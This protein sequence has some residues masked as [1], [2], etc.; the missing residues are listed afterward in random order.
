[1][2]TLI[3]ILITLTLMGLAL[4]ARA[5]INHKPL[6]PKMEVVDKATWNPGVEKTIIDHI[7]QVEDN[8]ILITLEDEERINRVF[9]DYRIP[10]DDGVSTTNKTRVLDNTLLGDRVLI[11]NWP[12]EN[13]P[14]MFLNSEVK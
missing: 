5:H 4:V 6:P 3:K 13:G 2:T 7:Y 9:R 1:M 12:G 11:S 14:F 10:E 8:D